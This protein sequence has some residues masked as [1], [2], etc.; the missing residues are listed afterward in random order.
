MR[1]TLILLVA[2]ALIGT[3]AFADG[4]FTA[5]NQ[6]NLYLSTQ[7]G[8]APATYGWG[9]GWDAAAN[10]VGIGVDQEYS[11]GWDGKNIGF[12]GTFEF[13]ATGL[14]QISWFGTYYKFADLVK[15]TLGAP[16][17]DYRQ[18]DYIEGGAAGSRFV[19]GNYSATIE[20][21]PIKGLTFAYAQFIPN[22]Q[23]A[24]SAA[25]TYDVSTTPWAYIAS[26]T[27]MDYLDNL[28]VGVLY[29]MDKVGTFTAQLK[30]AQ[31]TAKTGTELDAA[32]TIN[33][34]DNIGFVVATNFTFKTSDTPI[35]ALVSAQ[36][37]FAPLTLAATFGT[38]ISS[39]STAIAVEAKAE[40]AM[41][42]YAI[43]VLGGYDDGKGVALFAQQ[44]G[45]WDGAEVYP[46]VKANFD[47]G[48]VQLGFV[49][50]SGANGHNSLMAIPVTYSWS[51]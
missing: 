35:Y 13:G 2:L 49:Y 5:W 17:V 32:A 21:T 11:F 14:S 19:N 31:Q 42:A 41:G 4:K 51:F 44:C 43:G 50:A 30:T 24:N 27:P 45:D 39:A 3:A 29:T 23:T 36:A 15:L 16:R 37:A 10:G 12:S 25:S 1:K 34:I 8:S 26:A 38:S 7:V 18:Y 47:G 6:G 9:P 28:G 22:N 46:Y 48:Y 33:A 40:Y 20:V